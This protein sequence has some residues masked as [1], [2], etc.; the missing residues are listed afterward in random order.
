ML[1]GL[2]PLAI[3]LALIYVEVTHQL[4]AIAGASFKAAAVESARRIAEQVDRSMDEAEELVSLPLLRLAVTESNRRYG[5]EAARG[6]QGPTKDLLERLPPQGTRSTGLRLSAPDLVTGFLAR[7][8]QIRDSD[9]AGIL[10]VD[11]RG[12]LVVSSFPYVKD[13][14]GLPPAWRV[15]MKAGGPTGYLSEPTFDQDLGVEVVVVAVPILDDAQAPRAVLGA[16]IILMRRDVLVRA[17]AGATVGE[18]GHA[19]LFSSGG[20]PVTCPVM[21]PGEHTVSPDVVSAFGGLQPGWSLVADDSHGSANALIGFAPVQFLNSVAPESLGGKHWMTVVRQDQQE[22]YA[23]LAHLV[24]KWERYGLVV[25]ALMCGV[26]IVLARLVSRPIQML[27]DKV[28]KLGIVG[29]DGPL[30]L[31]TGDEI[32]DLAES[33]NVLT[34]NLQQSVEQIERLGSDVRQQEMQYRD[35]VDNAPEMIYHINRKGDFVHVNKAGLEKLNYTMEEMLAMKLADLLPRAQHATFSFIDQLVD[36][37]QRRITTVFLTKDGRPLD[38]EIQTKSV[39]NEDG[40][41]LI[42]AR[43]VLHDATERYRLEQQ[44]K[45]NT[46]NLEAAVAERTR[47]LV[48][49]QGRYKGLF[50]LVADS[51]FMVNPAGTITAVNKREEETLGHTEEAVIGRS[52]FDIV[53]ASYHAGLRRG[54]IDLAGS[55]RKLPTQEMRVR[56]ANGLEIPVD[57]DLIRIDAGEQVL[58]MVQVRDITDRKKL[59]RDLQT[60]RE[61]L[62]QAVQ[63]RTAEIAATKEYLENLLEN[64]NDVIYTLDSEGRFTY[65]SRKIEAWGYQKEDLLGR[66]YST[67]LASGGGAEYGGKSTGGI[68]TKQVYEIE[69]VT[70]TGERRAVVVSLSPLYGAGGETL[71][72]LGIARDMTETRKLEQ[73]IWSSEK[74]VSI[75]RLAAGVAHEMNNPLGGILNCLYNLRKGTVSASRQEE[76]QT[77]MENGVE[78]VQ[79][80]VR[81]LLHFSQQHEPAFVLTDINALLDQVLALTTHLFAPNQIVLERVRGQGLPSAMVDGSMIEQVLMNLVLNA[82]HAMKN[83]GTLTVQTVVAEGVYRVEIR[84]TGLGISPEVLPRIFDPFFTTKHEGEGTGLGLSVSLGI[85]E[86]HGGRITVKSAVGT[87][88]TFSLYLPIEREGSLL[89]GVS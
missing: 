29:L 9:Y 6:L 22:T 59:E 69:V 23:P 19:M 89:K 3:L 52:L 43:A 1:V 71:G 16:V 46:I 39:L 34:S 42:H 35:L 82:V 28:R 27:S 37:K 73:Q 80:I 66:P 86:R 79:K 84:D 87:G 44:L 24:V 70:R 77:S 56:H 74:L 72:V 21:A 4:Q 75:G 8:C 45:A 26:G 64:A 49:S 18:T 51:V 50:D 47:Q 15:I 10:V 63:A 48:M 33:F 41:E 12:A 14:F 81:Q 36:E 62:E 30:A 85:A 40:E 88:T 68:Q 2:L 32:H 31:R 83:G 11:Q 78:R 20:V 7:W 13:V 58:T 55:Q 5:R 67:L 65:V 54:F 17:T 61:Q 53:E 60:Y 25:L 76:Y 38:A 57:V